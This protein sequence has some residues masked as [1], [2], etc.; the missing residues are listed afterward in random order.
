MSY[1]SDHDYDAIEVYNDD[2]DSYDEEDED[3][4]EMTDE[5]SNTSEEIDDNDNED[6]D[7][8]DDSSVEIIENETTSN[9]QSSNPVLSNSAV[10]N[11][12]SL[13]ISNSHVIP[14]AENNDL[15]DSETDCCIICG[16]QYTNSDTHHIVTLRCGHLFGKSCI[17]R[18]LSPELRN[19]R[20]PT[21]SRTARRRE[22]I[23][24]YA[25]NLRPLDTW[26]LDESIKKIECYKKQIEQ[27]G[28]EIKKLNECNKQLTIENDFLKA[29][30]I[31]SHDKSGGKTD[32]NRF[33]SS[34]ISSNSSKRSK[35][36]QISHLK[37]IT[38]SEKGSRYLC[39]SHI[40]DQLVVNILNSNIA[41]NAMFP[42]FGVRMLNLENNTNEAFF[43]HTKVMKGMVLNS[44]EGTLVT[45]SLDK[46]MK[47][48][49]IFNKAVIDNIQLTNEPWSVAKMPDNNLSCVGY[50]NSIIDVYD[51]RHT[52]EP[53][54][55]FTPTSVDIPTPVASMSVI[56]YSHNHQR[57]T[58]LL[59]MH[60]DSF[61]LY[62]SRD[63]L[64]TNNYEC[65]K[66]PMQGKT[67]S[68]DFDKKSGYTLISFRPSQ[69]HQR[70]THYILD[71]EYDDQS[72]NIVPHIINILESGNQQVQLSQ[73]R[74]FTN[75][76]DDDSIL[77]CAPDDNSQGAMI[78]DYKKRF[79]QPIRTNMMIYDFGL[80]SRHHSSPRG[81][82]S[83]L[84]EYTIKLYKL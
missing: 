84:G 30:L 25:Q 61:W 7:F 55:T 83:C 11:E 33:K 45:I 23:K 34:T 42:G 24:I 49:S 62:F 67:L 76:N 77:I 80:I 32:I 75:L 51:R 29:K 81:L 73:S 28:A 13:P 20:C 68:C 65:F 38:F 8:D 26:K 57:K 60:L 64:I 71:F 14:N 43:L 54:F 6:D 72:S 48:S 58:A 2:T 44:S 4:A 12:A 52:S 15:L 39:Y 5:L 66:L 63:N 31:N 35:A 21:C 53:A 16:D 78:W 82:F 10:N 69:K 40:S 41:P 37:D 19:Q 59:S 70:T 79:T 1:H 50:R 36:F 56:E 3:M 47:H 18:W 74:I 46:T 17:E 27:M 22:I 9:Q